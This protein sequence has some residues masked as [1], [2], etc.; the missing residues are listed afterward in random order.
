M[1]R[2]G[3]ARLRHRTRALTAA[4]F[5]DLALESSPDIVQARCFAGRAGV[6]LVVVMRGKDPLPNAAEIRELQRLLLAAAPASLVFRITPPRIRRLRV[7]LKLRLATLDHGPKR[8]GISRQ[9]EPPPRYD[10]K[11]K[12]KWGGVGECSTAPIAA[13][14]ANAIFAASGKRIRSLPLKN[15]KLTEL[16]SL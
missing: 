4:D 13:A 12:P 16:A 7:V 8:G 11:G 15:L 6:R 14:I 10:E 2:F 3:T 1:L 5:E 9:E